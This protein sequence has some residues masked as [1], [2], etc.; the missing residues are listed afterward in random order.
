MEVVCDGTS[1]GGAYAEH[2]GSGEVASDE[3]LALHAGRLAEEKKDVA[4]AVLLLEK[5]IRLVAE[6]EDGLLLRSVAGELL[7]PLLLQLELNER[8][9]VGIFT[10]FAMGTEYPRRNTRY[11]GS[12]TLGTI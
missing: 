4:V 7:D 12:S 9:T 3:T 1:V 6:E 8:V 11:C 2:V 10:F 5:R